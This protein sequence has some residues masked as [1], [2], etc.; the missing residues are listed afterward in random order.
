[1][2][3][4]GAYKKHTIVNICKKGQTIVQCDMFAESWDRP[5]ETAKQM[6]AVGRG[7]GQ[8]VHPPPPSLTYVKK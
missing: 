8:R 1:M 5:D 3:T 2:S 4:H 6:W 7:Y